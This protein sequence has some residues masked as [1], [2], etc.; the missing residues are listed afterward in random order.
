[1]CHG[2]TAGLH[3]ETYEQAMAGGNFGPAIVP[4]NAE[5]SLLVKLQRNGH[6]NSLSSKELEWIE[7]WI[8]NGAPEM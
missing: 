3:L 4:G 5:E 2:G 8:N 6:P 7:L 1:M